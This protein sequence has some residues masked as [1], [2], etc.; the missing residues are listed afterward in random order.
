[1]PLCN[2]CSLPLKRIGKQGYSCKGKLC[3]FLVN[4]NYI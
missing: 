3:S 4:H 2:V 1:M